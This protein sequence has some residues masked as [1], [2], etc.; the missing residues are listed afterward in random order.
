MCRTDRTT[1]LQYMLRQ[2]MKTNIVNANSVHACA[3]KWVC[4]SQVRA[5]GMA[6]AFSFLLVSNISCNDRTE[7]TR[8]DKTSPCN[9]SSTYYI[10][11]FL[12]FHPNHNDNLIFICFK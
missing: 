8:Y 7:F 9:N 10:E 12:T 6:C 11:Y 1:Y 4:V 2:G 3:N 5:T